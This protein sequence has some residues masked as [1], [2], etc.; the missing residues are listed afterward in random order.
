MPTTPTPLLEGNAL[1]LSTTYV[2]AGIILAWLL[3][4]FFSEKNVCLVFL[5]TYSLAEYNLM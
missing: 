3:L 2:A 1:I 5:L 4:R